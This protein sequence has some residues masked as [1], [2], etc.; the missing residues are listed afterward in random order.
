M[1]LIHRL[2]VQSAVLISFTLS[3]LWFLVV[4]AE[5][6]QQAVPGPGLQNGQQ[7]EKSREPQPQG[8]QA[9]D[10]LSP[11]AVDGCHADPGYP[12]DILQWCDLITEY[13]IANG[14]PAD[15]I[16]AV[17]LLESGG[18]P[19]AYSRSGAVGLMQVMPRDGIAA[20]FDCINGPCFA[21]RPSIAE[22]QD[23]RFN[24]AYGSQ[25]LASLIQKHGNVRDA[26]KAYGPMDV[27]YSYADR[28]MAI[29][30]QHESP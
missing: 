2:V 13:A 8:V 30:A 10:A 4:P 27:G 15:L 11:G 3:A 22:L 18:Q 5:A 20:S 25:M 19:L 29:W 16:A 12:A 1:N 24:I 26:L 9:T 23:P 14:L 7:S 17:V 6:T 21:S 28:V